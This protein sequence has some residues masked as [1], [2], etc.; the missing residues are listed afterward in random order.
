VLLQDPDVSGGPQGPITQQGFAL[1]TVDYMAPEQVVNPHAVDIRADLYSLG[2]TFYEMLTGH[3]PFPTG[4]PVQKLVAHRTQEPVPIEQERPDVPAE[5]AVVLNTLLAK[6][7]SRRYQTPGEA[8]EAM[9]EVLIRMSSADVDLDWNP[10]TFRRGAAPEAP[11][12]YSATAE[13]DA[14]E[15]SGSNMMYL[16]IAAVVFV[17]SF[18]I[19]FRVL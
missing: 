5:V 8:A 4:S 7:P 12:E 16:A 3:V 10:P 19:L 6:H 13:E 9:G 15:A 14:P 1:G 18:L 17:I 11:E 2:C